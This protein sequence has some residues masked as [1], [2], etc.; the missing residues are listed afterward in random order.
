[1][2]ANLAEDENIDDAN[3][4]PAEAVGDA[5]F[6]P[7]IDIS[8]MSS[9]TTIYNQL[10]SACHSDAANYE[11]NIQQAVGSL[12]SLVWQDIPILCKPRCSPI[13]IQIQCV[14]L[15]LSLSLIP[16]LISCIRSECEI[17]L[18]QENESVSKGP[19]QWGCANSAGWVVCEYDSDS[20]CEHD[21]WMRAQ[22]KPCLPWSCTE[23][24]VVDIET[25]KRQLQ[26]VLTAAASANEIYGCELPV[27]GFVVSLSGT[28]IC[29]CKAQK[30]RLP[31]IFLMQDSNL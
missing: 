15:P 17:L 20:C 30:V 3:E 22:K 4:R 27:F 29:V 12:L 26:L 16:P 10:R 6:A 21:R 2:P 5:E 14:T 31:N 1:M 24:K 8:I 28:Y 25:A 18:V 13:E 23:V 7:P 9:L 19:G 11:A